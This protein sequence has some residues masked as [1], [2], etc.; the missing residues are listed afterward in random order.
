MPPKH[1]IKEQISPQKEFLTI[2]TKPYKTMKS[3]GKCINR[4]P[5]IPPVV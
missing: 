5:V 1:K 2:R 4:N 3:I